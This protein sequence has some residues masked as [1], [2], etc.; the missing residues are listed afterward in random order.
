MAPASE[1]KWIANA[2]LALLKYRRVV[3]DLALHRRSTGHHRF[4]T[5]DATD[6]DTSLL[7]HSYYVG[8]SEVEADIES[9]LKGHDPLRPRLHLTQAQSWKLETK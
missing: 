9:I 5:I 8:S 6:V 3:R 4:R 2:R 7:G 1:G